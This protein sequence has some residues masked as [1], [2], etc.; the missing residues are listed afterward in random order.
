M[1]TNSDSELP[2]IIFPRINLKVLLDTG[3]TKSFIRPEIADKYFK[4]AIKK[5]PFQISTVHGS[6][7]ENF[8]TTIPSIEMFNTKRNDMLKFYLFDFH[9]YFDCLLGVDN[10]KLIKAFI[11]LN[12]EVLILPDSNAKIYF[13]KTLPSSNF[14]LVEPRTEQIIEVQVSDI[15]NGDVII[16]Y[17]RISNLEIP[18]CIATVK[19]GKAICSILNPNDSQIKISH[20][21]PLKVDQFADYELATAIN[22]TNLHNFSTGEVKFDFSKIRTEQYDYEKFYKKGKLNKNADALSRI[23]LNA[24]ETKNVIDKPAIFDFM[25]QFNDQFASTSGMQTH[26]QKPDQTDNQSMIVEASDCQN[27]VNINNSSSDQTIHSSHEH[28]IIGIPI[29]ILQSIM[30]KIKLLSHK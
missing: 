3:S 16:P 7:V 10:L 18:E 14:I 30:V 23:E 6:S 19:N 12:K 15:A 5:D 26:N 17:T 13:H 11:D 2:Y 29:I 27:N 8:S 22:D 1:N 24:N 9:K 4:N 25:E 21:E 28:P 20:L